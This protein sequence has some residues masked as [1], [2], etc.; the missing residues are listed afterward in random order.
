M[1]NKKQK[2]LPT[3]ED[4][5]EDLDYIGERLTEIE[6]RCDK[7]YGQPVYTEKAGHA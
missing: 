1:K 4:I 3:L 5:L 7:E 6:D 2:S